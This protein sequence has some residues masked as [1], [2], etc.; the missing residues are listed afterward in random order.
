MDVTL[1]ST[2]RS[3]RGLSLLPLAPGP[4]LALGPEITL[5]LGPDK[6]PVAAME[7]AVAFVH[8]T[9]PTLLAGS[10]PALAVSEH[11]TSVVRELVDIVAR[12]C[13]AEDILGRV[14]FDGA[15]ITI[16][17]GEKRGTLPEPDVE[18]GLYLVRR[19]VDDIGQ[20]AGDEGGYVVW[21]SIPIQ[22]V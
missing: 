19:L 3:M 11:I 16:S 1:S 12:D 13:H 2:E 18:P 9:L 14:V 7:S 15:H 5:C 8:R 21:A 6:T 22:E 10:P 4:Q 17:I 20:Y